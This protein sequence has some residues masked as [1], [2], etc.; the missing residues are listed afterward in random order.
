[1][2]VGARLIQAGV[3]AILL[4]G[5]A[6]PALAETATS[7]PASSP[8]AE[9]TT[10]ATHVPP[11]HSPSA[12]LTP[13]P[14]LTSTPTP[15]GTGTVVPST[16]TTPAATPTETAA[17]ASLAQSR[18]TTPTVTA[19][20]TVTPTPV[21]TPIP[22]LRPIADSSGTV[23]TFS[24]TGQI[25]TSGPF[26]QSLGTN[27]RSCSSC[28]VFSDGWS[29]SP[30]HVQQR[31][32][33]TQGLDPIFRPVDGADSPDMDVSTIDA[34][35]IAYSMLLRKGVI[36]VGIGVPAGAEFSLKAVN[37]PYHHA[38][39][40]ELS[41]FRRPLPAT[42]LPFLSAIMWDGREPSL[43][44]QA[45]DATLGH[46]QAASP[47]TDEE[48]SQIV[49]FES[50][51]FTA[52]A[53]AAGVGD[54]TSGGAQGGAQNLSKQNFFIGIN[55]PLGQNPSGASFN[56]NAFT[57]YSAWLNSPDPA[58]Q[59]VARGE[60][61]FNNKPI[62]ITGVGGL[63]DALG[64]SVIQ[65]TCSMC[66]DALNVGDHSVKAPLNIGVADTGGHPGLDMSGMPS[67]TLSCPTG[68]VQTT[69]P[70]RALITGKCADIGKFKGPI[71]RGLA[72]RAPYFHNGSAATL[73][74][75]VTFYNSRFSIGLSA[76]EQSD[77]V[78]FL[79]AL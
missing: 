12:T 37:D 13:T 25:D 64:K 29:V 36:R 47:L 39:A 72:A 23:S 73:N 75:A 5:M 74:D 66:H 44:S 78:S 46:A 70:G 41:L 28:H 62:N 40:N 43:A 53:V 20:A 19:T 9:I 26:F 77:L 52:Q 16:T 7:T 63:N 59:A 2:S 35:R 58:K 15:T 6:S 17:A 67:Y 69:D 76:Q 32:N 31:F 8:R 49:A 34:R 55:D 14:S 56:P 65:G 11:A 50:A 60:D 21:A 79:Q 24:T 33:A 57:I 1:M 68:D 54:L 71:L 18:T 3:A 51:N 38:S 22:N 61:L 30:A 45:N 48:K 4:A 27:G 10:T 42:N